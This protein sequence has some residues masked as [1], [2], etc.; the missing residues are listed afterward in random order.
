[1]AGKSNSLALALAALGM[2][3]LRRPR[4]RERKSPSEAINHASGAGGDRNLSPGEV[5]GTDG[6]GRQA[7]K[8]SEI[9]ARGWKDI[10]KR[11]WKEFSDDQIPMISAGVTFYAL[12]ALFPAVAAVAGLYGLFADLNDVNRQLS[13]MSVVLPEGAVRLIGEQL[14]RAASAQGGGLSLAFIVGLAAA[15]W[16]ANGATKAMI[17]G[18]NIAYDEKEER[19][20]IA[21]TLTPLALTVGFLL[22]VVASACLMASAPF[23]G[24]RF[25]ETSGRLYTALCLGG[26]VL[27]MIVGVACL[28]R[29]GP[30]RDKVK[31]RWISWGSALAV[32]AWIAM[33]AAFTLYV[34]N[35]GHYDR[36]YGALGAAVGFMTWVWLSAQ[37]VLL[38]AELNAEIEHQTVKDTTVGP[39]LPMGARGAEMADT[40]GAP[41]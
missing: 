1:V 23:V 28:Y 41:Q 40:V 24:A 19:K 11:T 31:W 26:I 39:D 22:F 13:A 6:R 38:G 3:V 30:S 4:E 14:T 36:T 25:G 35:F 37:V 34:A 15:I 20:F 33:S 17:T 27:G 12:L 9:P 21:K 32:L 10:L 8:P 29:F 16:S 7:E 18:L 2:M 5:S